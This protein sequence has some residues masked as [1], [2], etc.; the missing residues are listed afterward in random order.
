MEN[1]AFFYYSKLIND[2]KRV[3]M[4]KYKHQSQT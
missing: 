2:K 3:Q 1:C 4:F